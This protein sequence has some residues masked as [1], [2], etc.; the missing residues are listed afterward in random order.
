MDQLP[1]DIVIKRLL[2]G[3][4]PDSNDPMPIEMQHFLRD[5]WR[6]IQTRVPGT[7]FN[8]DFWSNC[9]PRRSTYPACRAVVAAGNQRDEAAEAM[10]DAIQKAYYLQARNP[11]DNSTLVELA[12]EL[13]LDKGRFTSD[14]VA[15]E[16]QAELAGEINQC[17]AL[18]LNGFPSLALL[19][20]GQVTRIQHDYNDA[21]V[22]LDRLI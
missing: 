17:G 9:N 3:L 15:P 22:I 12:V 21:Q 5:T 1:D 7:Q 8:F 16:T 2:G 20:E 13:G 4:A 10:I 14:L 18:G 11:S 6:K 19:D